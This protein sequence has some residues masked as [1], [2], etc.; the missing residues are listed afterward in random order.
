MALVVEAEIIVDFKTNKKK[1]IY[2]PNNIKT[3]YLPSGIM[4]TSNEN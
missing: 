3:T 2:I 1:N 4:R